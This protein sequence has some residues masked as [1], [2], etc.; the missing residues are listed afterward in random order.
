LFSAKEQKGK[1]HLPLANR[2]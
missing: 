2:S 1:P